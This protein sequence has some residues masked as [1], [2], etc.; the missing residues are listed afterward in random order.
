MPVKIASVM[1]RHRGRMDKAR[2]GL[3]VLGG[4]GKPLP[5]GAQTP[6][7]LQTARDGM[8]GAKAEVRDVYAALRQ[9]TS[10]LKGTPGRREMLLITLENGDTETK[11][12]ATVKALRGAHIRVNVVAREAFLSDSYWLSGAAISVQTPKHATLAGADGAFVDIPW[13]WLFQTTRVTESAASG[14][15]K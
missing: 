10:T 8:S 15:A 12:E 2:F 5:P 3:A 11:L 4:K 1:R 13:G 6:A 7:I 9:L 14:H